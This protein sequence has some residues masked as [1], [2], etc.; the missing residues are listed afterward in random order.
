MKSGVSVWA[1]DVRARLWNFS[2][3]SGSGLEKVTG[4]I[5]KQASHARVHITDITPPVSVPLPNNGS[6]WTVLMMNVL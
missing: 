4:C 6:P 3:G 2:P 1:K 5:I